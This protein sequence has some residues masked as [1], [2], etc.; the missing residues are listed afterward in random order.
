ME[1]KW[2][3]AI[4]VIGGCGGFGFAVAGEALRREKLLRQMLE[5]LDFMESEIRYRLT[6][7][8]ELFQLCALRSGGTLRRLFLDLAGELDKHTAPRVETCLRAALDRQPGIP[9]R[10]RG[11]VYQLGKSLGRFDLPGQLQGIE[12]AKAG[13]KRE[14]RDLER[15]REQRLRSYRTLGLCAGAALAVLLI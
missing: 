2:F 3:G 5:N 7:L 6:A 1:Y 4:L 14:L 11:I 13:C 10:V 12:A 15:N 8:P 9:A